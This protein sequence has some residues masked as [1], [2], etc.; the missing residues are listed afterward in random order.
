MSKKI[1]AC[2]LAKH[3]VIELAKAIAAL[4]EN[5]GDLVNAIMSL[6]V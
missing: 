1:Q 2:L 3:H 5:D 4:K 6:T